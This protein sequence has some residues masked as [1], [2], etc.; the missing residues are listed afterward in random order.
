MILSR[1]LYQLTCK[2]ERT[3]G[4]V[5]C[6][7]THECQKMQEYGQQ[8]LE[9][10]TAV[11]TKGTEVELIEDFCYLG[12][13]KSRLGNCDKECTMRVGKPSTV[14]G[15]RLHTKDATFENGCH[16]RSDFMAKMHQL[17][18]ARALPQT[19]LGELTVIPQTP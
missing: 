11:I 12:S 8:C 19:P 2:I 9:D 6:W 16:Q 3:S 1:C 4:S 10:D 15:S 13:N 5:D 17:I 7:A 18:L 14:F